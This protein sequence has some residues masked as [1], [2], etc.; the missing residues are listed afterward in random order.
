MW[1]SFVLAVVLSGTPAFADTFTLTSGSFRAG[2]ITDFGIVGTAAGPDI[3]VSPGLFTSTM[4]C[5]GFVCCAGTLGGTAFIGGFNNVILHGITYSGTGQLEFR[6]EPVTIPPGATPPAVT[7]GPVPFTMTGQLEI[8]SQLAQPPLFD[9]AVQGAGLATGITSSP[10]VAVNQVADIRYEFG[11]A[12][13][14]P[15]TLY[16]GIT[17]LLIWRFVWWC[18]AHAHST[19]PWS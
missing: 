10:I 18:N 5:C 6:T 17:A 8:H 15:S 3:T 9:I 14:E 16:L 13:P 19:R 11:P 12:V 1:L 2:A 4:Q 7:F